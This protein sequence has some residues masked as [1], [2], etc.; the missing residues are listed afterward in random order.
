M[1]RATREG[2]NMRL[3]EALKIINSKEEP[4]GFMVSFEHKDGGILRAD[5]FPDKHTGEE[6]IKTEDEAWELAKKFA[7]KTKGKCIN[8]YVID[9][10][11]SPVPG[12]EFKEI[13]NR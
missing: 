4:K 9:E 8:I 3:S 13:R 5:H 1:W 12:Y 10:N 11:F 2:I 6:L 7:A